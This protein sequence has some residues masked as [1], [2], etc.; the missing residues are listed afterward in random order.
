[1]KES[2]IKMT[3]CEA[4]RFVDLAENMLRAIKDSKHE[5][6]GHTYY[7]SCPKESG[8]CRR[9]SLDLTRQLAKMRKP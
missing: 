3:I 8:A 5:S 9:A 1:M 6:F 7:S 2:E 4:R